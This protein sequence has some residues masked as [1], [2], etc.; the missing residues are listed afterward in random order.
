MEKLERNQEIKKLA[1]EGMTYEEIGTKFGISRQMVQT[2]LR[3]A[4]FKKREPRERNTTT[5]TDVFE[6]I[7]A[8][9][10]QWAGH[11]PFITEITA[12]FGLSSQRVDKAL[13]ELQDFG[14]IDQFDTGVNR[15]IIVIGSTWD[16]TDEPEIITDEDEEYGGESES[17]EGTKG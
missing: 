7:V 17:S 10:R 9:K 15:K 3:R 13:Q 4:G 8:H 5:A 16:Y 6:F 11:G 2:V 1:Q 14:Y 12:H